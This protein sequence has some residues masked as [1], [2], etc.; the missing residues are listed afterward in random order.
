MSEKKKPL[1]PDLV[2]QCCHS[3]HCILRMPGQ[4]ELEAEEGRETGEV[5]VVVVVAFTA[6]PLSQCVKLGQQRH[7]DFLFFLFSPS[8]SS[9]VQCL[10]F[11]PNCSPPRACALVRLDT[12]LCKLFSGLEEISVREDEEVKQRQTSALLDVD[13]RSSARC[14]PNQA[15]H[16]TRC[17]IP[18]L[19]PA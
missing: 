13:C 8:L 6:L 2:P 11:P 5:V 19:C 14:E 3:H 16:H 10:L 12:E 17:L 4:S 9:N 18:T 7:S 15:Q 1:L